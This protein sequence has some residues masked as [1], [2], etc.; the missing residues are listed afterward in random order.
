MRKNGNAFLYG[1]LMLWGAL[2]AGIPLFSIIAMPGETRKNA[3]LFLML[4]IGVGTAVFIAGVVGFIK[5]VKAGNVLKKGK[6]T[7][8]HFISE[9]GIGSMNGVPYYKIYFD[10]TDEKG[11][12][13]EVLS[14]QTFTTDEMQRYQQSIGFAVKY[15]GDRAAIDTDGEVFIEG[16]KILTA[17]EYCGTIFDGDKCPNCGAA[18]KLK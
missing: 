8:G 18:N 9:K 14:A 13:H 5:I 7:I 17:C 6:K 15:I 11:I 4:F 1:F 12:R 16:E 3:A 10:Y 2:F